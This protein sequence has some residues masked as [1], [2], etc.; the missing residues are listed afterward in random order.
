[1]VLFIHFFSTAVDRLLKVEKVINIQ[2]FTI[3]LPFDVNFYASLILLL[4]NGLNAYVYLLAL[5]LVKNSMIPKKE[6]G[7]FGIYKK[8]IHLEIK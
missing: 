4:Q 2:C 6:R 5:M 3:N 1:M 7:I 8:I